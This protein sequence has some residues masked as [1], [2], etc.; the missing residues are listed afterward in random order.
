MRRLPCWSFS[1]LLHRLGKALGNA[2]CLLSLLA[3]LGSVWLWWRG[4]RALV[5]VEAMVPHAYVE[6]NSAPSSLSIAVVGRWPGGA[7]ARVSEAWVDPSFFFDEPWNGNKLSLPAL[8]PPKRL[9]WETRRTRFAGLTLTSEPIAVY[10]GP[11]GKPQRLATGQWLGILASSYYDM[12]EW[13]E[14]LPIWRVDGIPHWLAPAVFALPPL[15]WLSLRSRQRY[16]GRRR[17]RRGLCLRCGYD[18]TG[19]AS[20]NCSECGQRIHPVVRGGREDAP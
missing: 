16:V 4:R 3:C 14:P 20:G 7:G 5:G 9:P 10:V 11:D 13:S 2:L 8:P 6:L 17:R 19:N 12:R 15:L 1:G 18:L